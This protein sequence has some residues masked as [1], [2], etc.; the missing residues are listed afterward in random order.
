MTTETRYMRSDKVLD[1][2]Q[3][4]NNQVYVDTDQG[5][6]YGNNNV[7]LGRGNNS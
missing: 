5:F 7:D 2:S 6:R 4:S 3:T 1:T